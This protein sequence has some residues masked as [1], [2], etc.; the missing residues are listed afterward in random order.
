MTRQW[1]IRYDLGHLIPTAPGIFLEDRTA[2]TAGIVETVAHL[3]LSSLSALF[4]LANVLDRRSEDGNLSNR[5]MRWHWCS[6]GSQLELL[7][8]LANVSNLENFE[9]MAGEDLAQASSEM[10]GLLR[11]YLR[12]GYVLAALALEK[13]LSHSFDQRVAVS[14]P[15]DAFVLMLTAVCNMAGGADEL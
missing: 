12:G 3:R 15:A 13:G 2:S 14:N 9:G 4:D 7:Q 10:I 6:P 8:D 11:T 5:V 1:D